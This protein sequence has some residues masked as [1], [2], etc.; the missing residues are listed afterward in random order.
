MQL[1][2][3]DTRQQMILQNFQNHAKAL[4][5]L[6]D[7]SGF[8][9]NVLD[10]NSSPKEV[11]GTAIFVMA[12]AR[13]IRMGWLDRQTY[14][15]AVLKGWEALK[16]QVEK[17]VLFIIFVWVLCVLPMSIIIIPVLFTTMIPMVYSLFYL[18]VWNWRN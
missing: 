12:F 5:A 10:I 15:P 7:K 17:M 9:L 4:L 6:Q 16:S 8:W 2:S 3:S 11:S 18:L 1:P 14:L 13:G